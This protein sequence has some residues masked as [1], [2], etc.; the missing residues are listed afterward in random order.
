MV[1]MALFLVKGLEGR[2]S[3]SALNA[4]ISLR[5]FSIWVWWQSLGPLMSSGL[6]RLCGYGR[7]RLNGAA[8]GGGDGSMEGC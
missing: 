1:E 3:A 2:M 4:C 8:G 7:R 6:E 5:D